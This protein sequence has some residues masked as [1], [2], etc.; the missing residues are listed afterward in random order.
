MLYWTLLWL[1]LG[2]TAAT[3]CFMA[4]WQARGNDDFHRF[5]SKLDGRP[6]PKPDDPPLTV[7]R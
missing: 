6:G 7:R 1:L 5:L 4:G 3:A 2:L